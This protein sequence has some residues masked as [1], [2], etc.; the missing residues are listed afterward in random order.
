MLR[1]SGGFSFE[2]VCVSTKK[3]P[4]SADTVAGEPAGAALPVIAA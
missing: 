1:I 3:A 2:S 4:S